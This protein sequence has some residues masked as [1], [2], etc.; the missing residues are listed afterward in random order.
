[1]RVADST[2]I[3]SRIEQAFQTASSTTGT[4]FD[5]LMKT[6]ARESSFDTTAKARTSSATGLFQFIESTWLE[7]LKEAGPRHGLSKYADQI[8][9]T[10]GGT[11]RVRDPQ[12]RQEILDLRKDPDIASLMAGALT[13]K[14]GAYLSQKLGR[15][16]SQGE[17]YIAHFLGANGAGRLIDAAQTTPDARA[18]RLFPAQAKANKAIFYTTAGAPRSLADVY[19]VLVRKHDG[20]TMIASARG[21]APAAPAAIGNGQDEADL[22]DL[23]PALQRVLSAWQATETAAPFEALFRTG[24][25]SVSGT[26]G[27]SFLSS[28]TAASGAQPFTRGSGASVVAAQLAAGAEQAPLDLTRFLSYRDREEPR[29]LMPPV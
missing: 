8:E 11:Y 28:Y 1:M 10:R 3:A 17:L 18:D 23:D 7:T 21:E 15:D 19:D 4:S 9:R 25:G 20:I 2:S 6:A 16:A 22:P 14:N 12:M 26:L 27:A 29:E 24:A 13:Q 5:Y